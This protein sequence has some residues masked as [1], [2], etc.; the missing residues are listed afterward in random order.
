EAEIRGHRRTYIG[1]M[2][3]RIIQGL[4]RAGTKNPVFM[5]DEIDKI[6]QDFRGDP[7]SALLEVLDPEQNSS[8][9]DHYIDVPFDLSNVMFIATANDLSPIPPALLDRMEVIRLSGY[10]AE[11][12]VEI[13]KAF[14]LPRQIE[15]CGLRKGDIEFLDEAI[16]EI[17]VSYTWESGVRSLEREISNVCRKIARQKA[18]GNKGKTVVNRAKIAELLGSQKVFPEVA[19][20]HAE[21]GLA[22]GL[23]WTQNGGEILFIEARSMPG[24]GALQLTGQLGSVMKESAQAALSY[25][26]SKAKNLG[27]SPTI[28]NQTDIHVHIPSGATPK[29]GPSAG[30]TLVTCLTSLLTGRPVNHDLAMTGEITLRGKVM[31]VG[32]IR[33]KVV[34]ARRSGIKTIILPRLNKNDLDLVPD[35][36]RS[37]LKF[38]FA[39]HVDDVLQHALLETAVRSNG[40]KPLRKRKV[41]R[42]PKSVA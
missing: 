9:N 24:N 2:P 37:S 33:E 36:V 13:A 42:K 32:G 12:K 38:V 1:A 16:L 26:R 23:A 35:Y 14:I 19:H 3:G 15:E 20:R 5:L 41:R 8:F 21:I 6:G 17:I 11:D 28:F 18:E 4:K 27:I 34:A 29:D 30:V 39:D 40:R 22:T 31:P 25:I 7:A 10:I